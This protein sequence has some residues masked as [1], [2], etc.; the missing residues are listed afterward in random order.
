MPLQSVAWKDKTIPELYLLIVNKK[1]EYFDNVS[2]LNNAKFELKSIV[3]AQELDAVLPDK[4]QN[5][6]MKKIKNFYETYFDEESG[7]TVEEGIVQLKEYLE[8][9]KKTYFNKCRSLQKDINDIHRE[10]DIKKELA[11]KK[12][13]DIKKAAEESKNLLLPII[14]FYSPIIFGILLTVFSLSISFK[15]ID[16]DLDYVIFY[17]PDFVIPTIVYTIVYFL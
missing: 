15:L 14:T 7:N 6:E 3:K 9:E 12:Q 2:Q 13:L 17:L 1:Q 5:A 11:D 8:E 4:S 16:F 10:L